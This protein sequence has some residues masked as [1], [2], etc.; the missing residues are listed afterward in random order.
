MTDDTARTC[1]GCRQ[2]EAACRDGGSHCCDL[3]QH[4]TARTGAAPAD[5]RHAIAFNALSR[6]LGKEDRFVALTERDRI[7]AAILDELDREGYTVA[8]RPAPLLLPRPMT[9]EE[10]A[11][12]KRQVAAHLGELDG[13]ARSAVALLA[14]VTS[15]EIDGLGGIDEPAARAS[16]GAGGAQGTGDDAGA[17][18]DAEDGG[19]AIS[20]A[21]VHY[22]V[23]AYT[24]GWSIPIHRT[25]DLSEARDFEG[26]PQAVYHTRI[27]RVAREVIQ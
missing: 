3:C 15:A 10:A 21:R 2:S 22:E 23:E 1:P 13:S 17:G 18:R 26:L 5:R 7:T 27:V 6:A 11:E 12:F 14:G 25:D 19:E 16:Q 8:Y 24:D 9:D 4:D 20:G